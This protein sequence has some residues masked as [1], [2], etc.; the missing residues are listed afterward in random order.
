MYMR[1]LS[2]FQTEGI[3]DSIGYGPCSL[4]NHYEAAIQDPSFR[5]SLRFALL[6]SS[7]AMSYP[8]ALAA[9]SG[10]PG[11][12]G[13]TGPGSIPGDIAVHSALPPADYVIPAQTFHSDSNWPADFVLDSVKANWQEWDRRLRLIVDQRG[14]GSYLNGTLACP[15]ATKHAGSAYNWTIS[16]LA[17]RAFIL[18]H[19]S[20][21]DYDVASVYPNSH[22]VY[23][24]L[25]DNHQNQ[26]PF[27][28]IKV[29]K[30][31]LAT[32]F[33]PNTPLSRTF[34]QI[35]KLHAR[36]IKMGKLSD[37]ELLSMFVL[38]ALCDH[39]PRL[40][41]SVNNMM[42]S[43]SNS[44]SNIRTRLLQ[45]EH[46]TQHAEETAALAAPSRP[47]RLCQLQAHWTSYRMLHCSRWSDGWQDD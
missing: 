16:D 22:G 14:F 1:P 29:F 21:H 31:A 27:A 34:D 39:Y 35:S 17:L 7:V 41:T 30:E 6:I 20:D 26:G 4:L 5:L 40:Q 13:S 2:R 10:T 43:P 15:D 25:R 33:V 37:D 38:N 24:V 28:K 19:V 8:A 18:E 9:A 36:F 47:P 42:M 3:Q 46:T 45:G 32:R 11:S 12:T 23:K 44:S